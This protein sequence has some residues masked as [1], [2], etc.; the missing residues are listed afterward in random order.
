MSNVRRLHTPKIGSKDWF[1]ETLEGA[2]AIIVIAIDRNG[3][4]A[5]HK[6]VDD[7]VAEGLLKS[8][9]WSHF[10]EGFDQ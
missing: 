4:L 2:R 9:L 5:F 3:K 10:G 7:T 6:D 8:T 1:D